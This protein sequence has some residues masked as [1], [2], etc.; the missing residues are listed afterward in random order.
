MTIA[1]AINCLEGLV[2]AADSA[3][4]TSFLKPD[5]QPIKPDDWP[6]EWWP[7]FPPAFDHIIYNNGNKIMNLRKGLP[8]GAM[9][10][11]NWIVG[12]KTTTSTFKDLRERFSAPAKAHQA[13][14]INKA[15][16]KIADVASRT[17]EYFHGECIGSAK[18]AGQTHGFEMGILVGG[19]GT[20]DELAELYVIRVDNEGQSSGPERIP[21]QMT[22]TWDG[23]PEAIMRLVLG[24]SSVLPSLIEAEFNLDPEQ[25]GV[26]MKNLQSS[27]QSN[28]FFHHMPIKDAIDLSEFLVDLSE[29]YSRFTPGPVSVGGPIEVAAITRHEGFK[30]IRRKHYYD[31]ALNPR[32]EP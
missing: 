20:G 25:V 24:F 9:A 10:W 23:E 22:M 6:E 13:W 19:F 16:F 7:Q 28:L 11:G 5:S 21:D 15:N 26:F 2:L 8:I 27:T 3:L 29:R 4:T 12:N 17:F 1:V 32:E 14:K 18:K 30:W 31:R